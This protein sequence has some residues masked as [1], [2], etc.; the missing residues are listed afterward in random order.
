MNRDMSRGSDEP[1]DA[2]RLALAVAALLAT[3]AG[4]GFHLQGHAPLPKALKVAF[5]EAKDHQSDF[6]QGLRKALIINGA[7]VTDASTDASAVVHVLQDQLTERV[8]A[9]SATNLPREYELTYTVRFSVTAGAAD[10]L[11][12]QEVSATRD[13]SFDEHVLL[14]K[15]NE[16][17]ILRQALAHDLVDVVMRRLSSL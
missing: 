3:L 9:V 14:A 1:R 12:A 8:L 7:R 6:V 10:L 5:V 15:D 13:F 16:E 2:V 4:C 17:D 11:T